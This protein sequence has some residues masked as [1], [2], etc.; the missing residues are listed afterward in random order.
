M[1][2]TTQTFRGY[3]PSFGGLFNQYLVTFASSVKDQ[4]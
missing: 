1:P 2:Q 3:F 4:I